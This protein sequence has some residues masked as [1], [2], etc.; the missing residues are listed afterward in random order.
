VAVLLTCADLVDGARGGDG[1]GGDGA[2]ALRK[3][4]VCAGGAAAG[5]GIFL[6]LIARIASSIFLNT[7]Y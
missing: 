3:G 6:P 4:R 7:L 2:A 1:D 5:D